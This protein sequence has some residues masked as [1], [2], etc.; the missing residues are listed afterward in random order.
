MRQIIL[1]A[2][3]ELVERQ[4]PAPTASRGE[5]L[6]RIGRVGVCG[7]DF[8]AF[9]GRHP[10]YTYPRVLGHELAGEVVEVGANQQGIKV[11]DRCAIDPYVSCGV[12]TPC[13]R[14]RTNCCEVLSVLGIHADGGMQALLPVRLDLLHKSD[15]LSLDQLALI[16]TLGIGAH[17]VARSGLKSGEQALVIGAGPIGLGVILFAKAAGA[18]VRVIEPNAF[19]R[20]FAE[21]LGANAMSGPDE[22]LADAVFDATG[23]AGSMGRSICYVA[24]T[25]RMVFVGLTRDPVSI[26]DAL[27]HKREITIY[28]SRNSCNQFPRIIRMME[29]GKIDTDSWIT[30]RMALSEVPRRLKDL[31]AKPTLIKGLVELDESDT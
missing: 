5:A 31:P 11:G 28:A 21:R 18:E 16:E 29:E 13:Q 12:C 17:A 15:T 22:R 6:L 27:L 2:P 26:D 4:L 10:A 9:A 14:G 19:R 23:S 7:S 25:G 20:T 8:H 30:D 3:G 24:P 1:Q